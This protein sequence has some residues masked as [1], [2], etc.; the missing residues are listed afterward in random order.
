M[1]NEGKGISDIIKED[2]LTVDLPNRWKK[3][4][5][6]SKYIDRISISIKELYSLIKSNSKRYYR[7]RVRFNEVINNFIGFSIKSKK[8]LMYVYDIKCQYV[9]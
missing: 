5:V 6:S 7:V 9:V 1:I 2:V 4:V 8:S 3:E